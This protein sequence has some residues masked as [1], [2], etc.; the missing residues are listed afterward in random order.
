[1]GAVVRTLEQMPESASAGSPQHQ[2]G[3]VRL[4]HHGSDQL[5]IQMEENADHQSLWPWAPRSAPSRT[6][7]KESHQPSVVF[8][9]RAAQASFSVANLVRIQGRLC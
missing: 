9:S 7:Q 4:S 1:M 3:N 8:G 2:Q 6:S 5:Q